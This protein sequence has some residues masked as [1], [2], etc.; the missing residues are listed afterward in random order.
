MGFV[1]FDK[2]VY[3]FILENIDIPNKQL[4]Q[5]VNE[6][7]NLKTVYTTI[8]R[9]KLNKFGVRSKKKYSDT[10]MK[11]LIGSTQ[12]IE[13]RR[14]IKVSE[15]PGVHWRINWVRNDK[16]VYEQHH[17]VTLDKS[18]M[19]L[20]LDGDLLNDSIDNLMKIDRST[21]NVMSANQ[22]TTGIADV[23]KVNITLAKVIGKTN[24]IKR[25]KHDE[26]GRKKCSK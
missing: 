21:R 3:D 22:L 26:Y 20:H 13:G 25:G 24:K 9:I 17:K 4:S 2:S 6:K 19:V 18:E 8:G 7:F 10:D 1:G 15:E 16:H 23:T 12:I 11:A 14:F 5:M